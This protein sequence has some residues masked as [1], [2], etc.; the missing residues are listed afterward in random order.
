MTSLTSVIDS[1][2]GSL[3][4][5]RNASPNT[6]ESYKRDL[7]SFSEN[8]GKVDISEITTEIILDYISSLSGEYKAT[9][10]SRKI[11]AIRQ[12]FGFLASEK[13][14]YKDPARLIDLPK[15]AKNLPKFLTTQ[16]IENIKKAAQEEISNPQAKR[17]LAFLEILSSSGL[18]ISEAV[19]LKETDI[20]KI[21]YQG[22]NKN[23]LIVRGKGNKERIVP[24]SDKTMS[25]L[26]DYLEVR[27]EFLDENN[28]RIIDD[29]KFLFPS[30]RAELGHISRQQAANLIKEYA[31]KANIDPKKISPHILRH[32]FATNILEKGIDL[33]V[34]Q[35]IL[36]HSDIST[37][38][39]YTH[40]NVGKLKRFVEEN[41]PLSK[42]K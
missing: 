11:S 6:L 10:I 41:H 28:G 12:F 15:K 21:N 20:Q 7:L 25:V 17:V 37:T 23:F 26:K 33:R 14:I 3:A 8:L 2:L 19:S 30:K 40:T 18:R 42:R 36:G 35:E 31:I 32:S 13:I 34:L 9:S 1:F 39:I 4:F 24:L 29:K 5:E 27:K 22:S 16:E 38:Q